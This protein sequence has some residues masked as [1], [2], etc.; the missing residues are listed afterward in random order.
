[1]HAKLRVYFTQEMHMVGHHFQF[2]DRRLKF[3]RGLP[4]DFFPRLSTPLT[5]TLRR[6]FG[7]QTT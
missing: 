1:M 2:N 6:Y 7:H 5:S 3:S 4:D